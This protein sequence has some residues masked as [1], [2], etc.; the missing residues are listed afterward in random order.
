M[1]IN[2]ASELMNY[3][4][5]SLA[6]TIMIIFS[7]FLIPTFVVL[8]I[9]AIIRRA[10]I[11]KKIRQANKIKNNNINV[12]FRTKKQKKADKEFSSTTTLENKL[13]NISEPT[14]KDRFSNLY[15]EFDYKGKAIRNGGNK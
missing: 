8:S 7:Y 3:S 6:G 9:T 5:L 14:N 13:G 12:D 11:N 15:L 4:Q 1:G 2:T 10:R